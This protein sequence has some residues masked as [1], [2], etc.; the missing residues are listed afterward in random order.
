PGPG[1]LEPRPPSDCGRPAAP[2]LQGRAEPAPLVGHAVHLGGWRDHLVRPPSAAPRDPRT[3]QEQPVVLGDRSLLWPSRTQHPGPRRRWGL[4]VTPGG[5][6]GPWSG[7]RSAA[8]RVPRPVQD[9][10]VVLGDGS[11]L[12]PSSTEHLGWRAHLERTVDLET[13][14]RI[15]PL[16]ARYA[17][18]AIQPC[19]LTWP[20]GRL[21]ILCRTRQR[22]IATCWSGD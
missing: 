10:P 18:G 15:G 21:Q 1:V 22:V 13:W 16:N 6:G 19:I 14:Q 17:F 3:D 4:P 12:C 2:V 7:R 9:Q 5:G 8:R 11:L 20:D